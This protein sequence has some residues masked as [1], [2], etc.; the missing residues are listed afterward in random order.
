[1]LA[2]SECS[3]AVRAKAIPSEGWMIHAN[4]ARGRDSGGPQSVPADDLRNSFPPMETEA[5]PGLS[6]GPRS[7]K[8]A[9][10]YRRPAPCWPRRASGRVRQSARF[11]H[12]AEHPVAAVVHLSRYRN[13]ENALGVLRALVEFG[14]NIQALC[15]MV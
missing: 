5:G 15:D 13:R 7:W 1:M 6:P 4:H 12:R 8:P 10:I 9:E 11:A 3:Y 14:W 2:R